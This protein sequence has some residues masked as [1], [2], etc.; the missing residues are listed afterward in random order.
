MSPDQRGFE[1][2]LEPVLEQR[3]W[4]LEA[5]RAQL[6]RAQRDLVAAEGALRSHRAHL[7]AQSQ[8]LAEVMLHRIDPANHAR[9]VRWLA[10]LRTT[11]DGAQQRVADLSAERARAAA[12]CVARQRDVEVIERH[13]EDCLA[14]FLREAE[15]R[16]A[17]VADREWLSRRGEHRS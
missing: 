8:Q 13:R 6:G 10:E 9:L 16:Q 4:R 12:A 1:Y 15:G 2:A 17:A 14:E 11:I 5:A 3:R 7:A